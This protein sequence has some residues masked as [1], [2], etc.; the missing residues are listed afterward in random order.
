MNLIDGLTIWSF[1]LFSFF[2]L[3]V[4]ISYI[5]LSNKTQQYNFT[6]SELI[7]VNYIYAMTTNKR[8]K[9]LNKERLRY[10]F[11]PKN[12]IQTTSNVLYA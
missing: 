6:N 9:I 3:T 1:I 5:Q 10:H 4:D 7:S 12:R 11:V 8:Y 2:L